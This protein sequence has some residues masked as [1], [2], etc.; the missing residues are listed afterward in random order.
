MQG[1]KLTKERNIK[2]YNAALDFLK[3]KKPQEVRLE[4]YFLG[5]NRNYHSLTD[6]YVRFIGSA[7]NYQAMPNIIG[8]YKRKEEFSSILFNFDFNKIAELTE[9]D[10]YRNFREKFHVTSRETSRNSWLKWS[11]AVIDSAKF[12]GGFRDAEDFDRFVKRFNY[13]S[14]SRMALPLLIQAKISGIGFA[15]A[16]DA[17]KELGYTDYSKPDVH[18]IEVFQQVGICEGNPISVYEAIGRMA[19]DCDETPYKVDKVFWL[20]CSGKYYEDGITEKSHKQEL[21]ALLKQI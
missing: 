9:E 19:D 14:T 8:F 17:L 11:R 15:L 1:I 10:L 20:I 3:S 5:E 18:L 6:V 12:I 7:Q 21:I 4:K 13:N 2:I 16:C